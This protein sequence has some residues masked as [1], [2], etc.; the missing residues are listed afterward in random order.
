MTEEGLVEGVVAA[1]AQLYGFRIEVVE[2]RFAC[3]RVARYANRCTTIRNCG[4]AAARRIGI[5]V[6]AVGAADAVIAARLA[7]MRSTNIF[8]FFN[9]FLRVIFFRSAL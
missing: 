4:R 2:Q 6:R 1:V 9:F 5:P 7:A 8:E 3:A